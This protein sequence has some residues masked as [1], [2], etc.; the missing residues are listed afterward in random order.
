MKKLFIPLLLILSSAAFAHA[1]IN[2]NQYN[3]IHNH[4]GFGGARVV[5]KTA[6]AAQEFIDELQARKSDVGPYDWECLGGTF[7]G[8]FNNVRMCRGNVTV[9]N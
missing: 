1:P 7:L 5:K 4:S 9:Q 8:T 2:Q 6:C 3:R